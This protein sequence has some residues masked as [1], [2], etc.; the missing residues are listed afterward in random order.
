M[1]TLEKVKKRILV[2][3]LNWG[4]GHVTR[5]IPII[6]A[7]LQRGIEPVLAS[8]GMALLLLQKEFPQL[9]SYALPSYNIVYKSDNM[10]LNMAWQIPRIIKAIMLEK[11]AIAKIVA[12]EK[13]DLII[14]DNR[15]GCRD[16]RCRNVFMTHQLN[17]KI[18][19]RPLAALVAFFNHR[20]IATFDECW[21]PDFAEEPTLAGT[22]SRKGSLSNVH[23]LGCLSRMK[24]AK[25]GQRYDLAIVL[26]GPEPQRTYLEEKL[27]QQAR[28][29]R[30]NILLI[31]GL[32]DRD[33]VEVVGQL[34]MRS[35][36]TSQA[37]NEAILASDVVLCRSGYSSLMD[38]VKLGKKAI[39][40]PT[41]GQTEQEYLAERFGLQEVCYCTTQEK[42][43]LHQA[44]I[45]VQ[46]TKGFFQYPESESI[47]Q[48]VLDRVL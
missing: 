25:V 27:I 22:L 24:P 43:D 23:Y 38:L 17:I 40:I 36:L 34:E 30:K 35:Y 15:Y 1:N 5:C 44:L 48:A 18:P 10:L 14:S 12:A 11:K 41:P 31:R 2:A 29:D 21:V 42:L 4:L 46:K 32:T 20:M 26:S 39:L 33:E 13:I 3:P 19:F 45:E 16:A 28:T 8:D 47:L 6:E 9:K 7:L 37:L